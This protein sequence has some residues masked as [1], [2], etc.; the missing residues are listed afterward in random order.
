MENIFS[1]V[2]KTGW[3]CIKFPDDSIYFGE[4]AIVDQK[5]NIVVTQLHRF[6]SSSVLW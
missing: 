6:L 1:G 5:G 4:I 2:N 3:K